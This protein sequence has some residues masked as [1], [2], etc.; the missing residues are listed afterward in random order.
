MAKDAAYHSAKVFGTEVLEN[1]GGTL[2]NSCLSN[3]RLP[4]EYKDVE[5]VAT[6]AGI[7]VANEDVGMFVRDWMKR[8]S[9]S[10]YDTFIFIMFYGGSWWVRW[11]AQPYLEF[12][13]FE[14]G[15]ETL[16]KLCTRVMK[17]EF[18]VVKGKL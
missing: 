3:T 2:T 15:T 8:T 13:D 9:S 18:A 17:G 14:W 4:L 16:K 10:D 5:A 12:A 11:S 7:D 6:K 1:K